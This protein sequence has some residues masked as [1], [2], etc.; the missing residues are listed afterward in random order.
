VERVAAVELSKRLKAVGD[1]AHAASCSSCRS[2]TRRPLSVATKLVSRSVQTL[3]LPR[4]PRFD[5]D[6]TARCAPALH[7]CTMRGSS[8]ILAQRA[9]WFVPLVTWMPRMPNGAIAMISIQPNKSH[10]NV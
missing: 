8:Q 6:Q 3:R 2:R 5:H 10:L 1:G 4:G 7:H 9:A